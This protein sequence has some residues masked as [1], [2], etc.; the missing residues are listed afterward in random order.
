MTKEGLKRLTR[1]LFPRGRAFNF[2][3]FGVQDRLH[4]AMIEQELEVI[5]AADDVQNS[6]LPDNDNYTAENASTWERRLGLI[7]NSNVALSVRKQAI[8]RKQTHPGTTK[9]RQNYRFIEKQLQAAGFDCKVYPNRF[10]DGGTN[11][12]KTPAEVLGSS[13][14]TLAV[15]E[16]DLQHGQVQHGSTFKNIVANYIEETKDF[17]FAIGSSY[18]YTFYIA[19]DAID[20]YAD[21]D[22]DRKDEFRQLILTLKPLH[23]MAFLFVNYV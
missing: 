14:A 2:P 19:G 3:R 15:H 18:A 12:T 23:S 13:P 16:T 22:A 17:A 8:L 4:N 1:S 5:T 9:P 20:E 6:L 21:I 11:I 10:D 7:S